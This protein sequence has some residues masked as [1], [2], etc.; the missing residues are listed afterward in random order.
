MFKKILFIGLLLITIGANAHSADTSTTMLV[1]KENGTWVLQVSASLTAF[2]YEIRKHFAETPYKTPEEFQKMVLE[3]LKNNL[4]ISFNKSNISFGNGMVK[5]G[6]ETRVVFE[7]FG[8]P[9]KFE[10]VKIKNTVFED[11]QQNKSALMLF[12]KGFSKEQFILNKDNN[13]T[14]LLQVKDNGFIKTNP[15][16]T[17]HASSNIIMYIGLGVVFILSIISIYK[18]FKPEKY[19]FGEVE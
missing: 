14:L 15:N 18:F 16:K 13:H 12:K 9:S 19:V 6:H 4:E 11:I 7:V 1:E 17:N 5:L 3:H 2:Q 8:I 10:N